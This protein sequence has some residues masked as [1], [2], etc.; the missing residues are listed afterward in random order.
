MEYLL[1]T[2]STDIRRIS[3]D[4][5]CYHDTVLPLNDLKYAVGLDWTRRRMVWCDVT[6]AAIYTASLEVGS[7]F[8]ICSQ[9]TET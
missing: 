6:D 8:R 2:R 4:D 5:R 7:F 1:F 3:L 9:Y